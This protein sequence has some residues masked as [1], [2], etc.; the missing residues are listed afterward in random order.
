MYVLASSEVVGQ[1]D[2]H[3]PALTHASVGGARANG[4]HQRN[5]RLPSAFDPWFEHLSKRRMAHHHKSRCDAVH[6][7]V[8][9]HRSDQDCPE[10]WFC[11]PDTVDDDQ[12]QANW[13]AT[14][15]S[16]D[17]IRWHREHDI[18][19]L[20]VEM[21]AENEQCA[22]T[23]ER[24]CTEIEAYEIFGKDPENYVRR[25]GFRT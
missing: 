9:L 5:R 25:R 11:C 21:F 4:R 2:Q 23:L 24:R 14:G 1:D 20:L 10:F 18:D 19:D 16:A 13:A 8:S 6:L 3:D 22:L 17:E 15:L 12:T 7:A